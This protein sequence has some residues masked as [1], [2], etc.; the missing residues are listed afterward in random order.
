MVQYGASWLTES[1]QTQAGATLTF[2]PRGLGSEDADFDV[3]RYQARANFLHLRVDLSRR[4]RLPG[5][6]ELVARASGQYSNDP[7]IGSEQLIGGGAE[8]VRGY[9]EAQA[10][11]DFGGFVSLELRGPSYAPLIDPSGTWV[12]ELRLL[13]FAE[14]GWTRLW[15]PLPEQQAIFRLWSAGVGARLKLFSVL[16]G[17]LDVAVPLRTEGATVRFLPRVLFRVWAEF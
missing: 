4:D 16:S 7:L 3:K 11:G 1:S 6:A 13:L 14:G 9:T 2:C 8:S 12:N 10:V 5:G 17:S 15:Q